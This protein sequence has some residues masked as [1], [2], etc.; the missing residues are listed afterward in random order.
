MLAK[1]FIKFT[2]T[3]LFM[4]PK[5]SF[6][7]YF[8][9]PV[10]LL[11]V[12]ILLAI[13]AGIQQY[14]FGFSEFH[15]PE[16]NIYTYDIV[17]NP[18]TMRAFLGHSY[19]QYNNY[20]V[21]RQ[22]YFHLLHAQNLYTIY[23]AEQWDLF[24]YS[25]TFALLMAP[26]AHMPDVVG[27]CIWNLINSLVLFFAIRMLPLG[28]RPK[29]W[30]LC[31][32]IIE[33]LTSLQ[34]A[35]S[36]ALMAGLVIAALGCMQKG[37]VQWATLW[38]VLATLIK[39]YGGIGF[40][41]FFFY[42]QKGR[43]ILYSILWTC[44]F[45][46]L[47]LLVTPFKTLIWQYHN[48]A[49]MLSADQSA[50]YGLSVMGWLHNWFGLNSGKSIVSLVGIILFLVPLAKVSLYKQNI[51]RLFMLAYMLIWVVI[52][53]HKAESPTF[54]IAVTG[55]AIWY[56]SLQQ[57]TWWQTVLLLSVFILTCLS[58]TDLFPNT[59]KDNFF[60]PYSIKVIPC[61]AVW[62]ALL[63]QLLS[64]RPSDGRYVLNDK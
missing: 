44:I 60:I 41:L 40:Y 55:V 4:Q 45:A 20:I 17:N 3:P 43:F 61:I 10:T 35:Q 51:Y 11:V 25:P 12:Y 32:I 49:A 15:M 63:F 9:H 16:H 1:P 8:F 28:T 22:S 50:S 27:L 46:A 39:V 13:V 57:H 18:T 42:P 21:F 54:V 58:P 53:N 6:A 64:M 14:S 23:P 47:P 48:W 31:F 52:F 24:K 19:S 30:I 36:N 59:L 33:L 62:C 34:N 29:S 38:L 2:F 56:F 7:F 5:K 37:K 26:F